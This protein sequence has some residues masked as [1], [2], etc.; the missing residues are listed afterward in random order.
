M[1]TTGILGAFL[2]LGVAQAGPPVPQTQP[3]PQ[4]RL[5][6]PLVTITG[7]I[8]DQSG[9]VM[10][11]AL[12][13]ATSGDVVRRTTTDETGAYRLEV[14]V[15]RYT[16]RVEFEGFTSQVIENVQV[17]LGATQSFNA[18]VP[19][20]AP[21]PPP[22]PPPTDPNNIAVPPGSE[23]GVPGGVTGGVVGGSPEGSAASTQSGAWW[24]TWITR[25]GG[26]EAVSETMLKTNTRY[27][28]FLEL[29][30]LRRQETSNG[31]DSFPLDTT[32]VDRLR[33]L[34]AQGIGQTS[35]V[36]R[37]TTVGRAIALAD[38]PKR[39]SSWSNGLWTAGES[40][41][42][43]DMAVDIASLFPPSSEPANQPANS[44]AGAVRVTLDAKGRGCAVVAIAIWDEARRIPLDHL[45]RF[46]EVGNVR[47]PSRIDT[48]SMPTRTMYP[49][50]GRTIIPD[51]SLQIF[52]F[53]LNG[54]RHTSYM[55]SLAK[56]ASDCEH[57]SWSSDASLTDLVL[58][59][60][61]FKRNL[62]D[63]RNTPG[64][65]AGVARRLSG[66]L[67]PDRGSRPP[68]GSG[69][70]FRALAA[71]SATADVKLFVR[72]TDDDGNIGMLP[73]GLLGMLDP[74][75]FGHDIRVY[76]PLA[77]ETFEQTDCVGGWTFV[78]PS[79]LL[80]IPD[81]VEPPD[82]TRTDA[83][84]LHSREEFVSKW[85]DQPDATEPAGVVLLAHHAGGVLTFAEPGD[86]VTFAEF[87]RKVGVGTI[88][89]LSACET[90]NLSGNMGVISRLNE[91]GADAIVAAAFEF[92]A[93]FGAYFAYNFSEIVASATE[94]RLTVD[95]AFAKALQQTEAKLRSTM[96]T[97]AKGASLELVLAGNPNLQICSPRAATSP[98]Q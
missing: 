30:A 25:T 35:L 53:P 78:L 55:M 49:T 56:P 37:F 28:L 22:P 94:G 17:H 67:F 95:E 21:P 69:A 88:V 43:A 71:L 52:E 13:I 93:K 96:G 6:G 81:G 75:I 44:R 7:T 51:A 39:V 98:S 33:E 26:S 23:I 11:G 32:L 10:P 74:P 19:I 34:L 16:L 92:P 83:R 59:N 85:I 29:S 64:R 73:V 18:K 77:R 57:Y 90:G 14:P 40:G 86:E 38:I 60:D 46:V 5:E 15:G 91:N 68:C 2:L 54:R 36:V 41:S 87:Q 50:L 8:T 4:V 80:G 3:A 42:S 62:N 79:K 48:Q 72:L 12:V 27:T 82:W 1:V 58:N 45:V 20:E 70:A 89:I 24:N 47:C 63:A 97:R 66:V 31:R 61:S 9:A 84:V 65:Y 76:Q